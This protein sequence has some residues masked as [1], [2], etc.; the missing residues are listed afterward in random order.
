MSAGHLMKKNIPNRCTIADVARYAGVSKATVSRFLNHRD[1]LLSPQIAKRVET[2]I[3]DLGY[4]PSPMAQAL[5]RGRSRLIGLVV[6]DIANLPQGRLSG[7]AV[8]SGQRDCQGNGGL[9]RLVLLS[10]G[11]V[12]SQYHGA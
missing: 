12:H 1:T 3:A 9:A 8:Q 11:G 4:V 10:G 6:A 2:A 7:H 5:K